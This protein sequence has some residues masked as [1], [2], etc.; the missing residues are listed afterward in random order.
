MREKGEEKPFSGKYWDSEDDGMYACA[1]CGNKLFS[2]EDKFDSGSGFPSFKKSLDT[3]KIELIADPTTPSRMELRCKNCASHLGYVIDGKEKYYQLNSLSLEL[4][5]DEED[6]EDEEEEKEEGSKKSDKTTKVKSAIKSMAMIAATAAVSVAIGARAG[7]LICENT[8]VI[9]PAP[10]P[11]A[12]AVGTKT[13][14]PASPTPA[15]AA[16]VIVPPRTTPPP[17]EPPADGTTP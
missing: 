5:P 4:N 12:A 13:P 14:P 16:S 10:A 9:P 2:S 17:T 6:E 11:A 15:P 1:A 8:K 7:F 3:K